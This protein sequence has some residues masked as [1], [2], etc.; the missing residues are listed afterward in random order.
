MRHGRSCLRLGID[1]SNLRAGGGVTHL[2]QLLAAAQPLE[3]GF[4]SVTAWAGKQTLEQLPVR[5]WLLAAHDPA[6]DA[7]LP[8]RLYWQHGRLSEVA[9]RSCD[10]LFVPGGNF[11]G[12]FRPFVT[13]CRNLL[14][15]E[16][17]ERRRYGV[18]MQRLR[19]EMLLRGQSATFRDADGIIFLTDYARSAVRMKMGELH[20]PNVIIA[21]GVDDRF[22]IPPRQQKQITSC[23]AADPFRLLHVSTVDFYKHQWHVAEGVAHLRARYPVTLD[24][25][26][27]AYPPALERLRA[28]MARLDPQG[29]WLR[30]R[31]AV[32]YAR[33]H[34]EYAQ[35]DA[36]VFASSCE[37]LPNILVEAMAAGLPIASSRRG[38]MPEVLGDAGVFFD[39]ENP[40]D[41]AGTLDLFLQDHDLRTRVS[42]AAH[43]R[44][45]DFSWERCARETF[46]F[47]ASVAQNAEAKSK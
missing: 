13:M 38:P 5:Q 6:L 47:L 46:A 31:G 29:A 17:E 42:A 11:R 30:Y 2:V 4:H 28:T 18:S 26:G 12:R 22:R 25:V 16:D 32:P 36:F 15:F 44:A 21:H 43:R 20:K 34:E 41:I 37:N 35:A 9:A 23:S 7:S 3:H 14:P 8:V 10:L 1:A 40:D 33:L 45:Q 19:L 27:T 39:P 24:L